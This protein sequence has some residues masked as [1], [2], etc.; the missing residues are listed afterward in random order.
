M[1]NGQMQ[2]AAAI[3]TALLIMSIYVEMGSLVAAS[4]PKQCGAT[5]KA[6]KFAE[7]FGNDRR[8]WA[9][10]RIGDYLSNRGQL[11]TWAG[12]P[13]MEWPVGS[14]KTVAFASGFWLAGMK[15]GE[16]VTAVGEYT[17][18]FQ[19]GTVAGH[20]TGLA[21]SP[22]DP[23]DE[24]FRIYII[25]EQDIANPSGNPDYLN[26][27]VMDGA[28][29]D[30]NGNPLLLGTS[31]AW[32]V[33]NDFNDSL[34][35]KLFDTEPMGVEVQ[36][37]AWAF[38]RSDAFGD[39][40]FFKFKFINKSGVNISNAYA[41]F[42]TDIDIGDGRDLVGCDTT[43]SLAYQYKTR[44]DDVYGDNP[45]AM[46]YELLQGPIV[47]S[48]G[49]TANVSGKKVPGFRNLPMTSFDKF[50]CGG[51]PVFSCPNTGVEAYNFMRGQNKIGES[52]I[53]STT[54]LA[55]KFWHAGDPVTGT[56]WLDGRHS[57]KHALLS[58]GPF[59]F[60]DGD[61]QEVVCAII[62]AQGQTGLESVHRLKQN[63]LLAQTAY[64]KQWVITDVEEPPL[65]MPDSYSLQQNYP[66]P[67]NPSTN[68][69]FTIPR[70]EFV[71]LKIYNLLGEEVAVVFAEKLAAGDYKLKWDAASLSSGIYFYQLRAGGFT[72]TRK[73]TMLR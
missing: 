48:S 24:R 3:G 4:H 62:I 33:F 29:V 52:I 25:N 35:T 15:S 26:W 11:V 21:G 2:I 20:S 9:P 17:S 6:E 64:D 10:N 19:P 41:A 72:Q 27:P 31:T 56:G 40:M 53:D 63:V 43:L 34:H 37:T 23:N 44:A 12:V 42:W 39:M 61:T 47:P 46:G 66:N 59:T 73:L 5:D 32:A 58:S 1:R 71:S 51:T 65:P 16:I 57:D 60:A 68:F 28:P 22:A 45:P 38:G 18:E 70:G 30:G 69:E 67:F 14:G 13:G 49:D 7:A 55:T 36:M 54:G 50:I 8:F